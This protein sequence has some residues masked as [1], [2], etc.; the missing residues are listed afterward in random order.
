MSHEKLNGIMKEFWLMQVNFRSPD[1]ENFAA[2]FE[3]ID[4]LV[5]YRLDHGE[6]LFYIL[7]GIEMEE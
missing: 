7:A 5:Q 6:Y 4:V 3:A 2:A 1:D